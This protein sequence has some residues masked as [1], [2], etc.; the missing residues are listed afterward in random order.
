MMHEI[1]TQLSKFQEVHDEGVKEQN[2]TP[3]HGVV[4]IR[5]VLYTLHWCC[6]ELSREK[7]ITTLGLSSDFVKDLRKFSASKTQ[8]SVGPVS[9][10]QGNIVGV[11]IHT[12]D[13]AQYAFNLI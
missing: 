13:G 12:T 11:K 1:V 2:S 6:L 10:F 9:C 3:K 4:H 7:Y 8:G 5:L